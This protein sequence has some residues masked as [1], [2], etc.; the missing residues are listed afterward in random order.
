MVILHQRYM[1]SQSN[2]YDDVVEITLEGENIE[3]S[4]VI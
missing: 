3:N 4:S 1:K 2:A